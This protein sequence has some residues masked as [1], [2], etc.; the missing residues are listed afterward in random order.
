MFQFLKNYTRN[1][2][3]KKIIALI[4]VPRYGTILDL[5]CSDGAFIER[6]HAVSP[7]LKLFGVDIAAG[8]IEQA[9]VNFPYADFRN[10]SVDRLSF[11]EDTFDMVFSTMSLHHYPNVIGFLEEVVR[12]L[13]PDG[14]LYITDLI[15]RSK[16]TQRFQNW[17]GCPET[18]HF[19]KFYTTEDLKRILDTLGFDIR[20]DMCVSLIPRIRLISITSTQK[21]LVSSNIEQGV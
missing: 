19:E 18:Y 21:A 5:S 15:P 13:K 20:S 6:L 11:G 8:D 12:I 10:E 16:W 14:I 17:N 1:F 4:D 3:H 2:R 7:D 9:K